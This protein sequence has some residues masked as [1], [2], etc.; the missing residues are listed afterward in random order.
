MTEFKQYIAEEIAIDHADG[1]FGRREAMRRLGL[2]GLSATA[3]TAVLAACSTDSSDSATASATS[4]DTASGNASAATPNAAGTSSSLTA[5]A[6]GMSTAVATAPITFA[7]P[8]G[9]LQ[10]AFAAAADPRGAVLVIHENKGLT[11]HIR[12]IAGRLAG[13]GY[14][15][16]AIDLLSE[17]GGT[18]TFAD[19]ARATAALGNVPQAR[20]V[21]DMKAG[22]AE[23]AQRVP[24]K[25]I[26]VIGFCFGGGQ[27][28]SLLASG[29][30][31]IAAAVPFYGPLPEG[32]NFAGS[33]QAAVLA[34]Y[35]GLD[36]RVNASRPQAE[37]ALK[38][39]GLVNQIE[40]VPDVDHAFFND[41]G[42]RYK[43]E[44]AAKVYGQVLDWFGRYLG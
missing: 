35:A 44:A 25:K 42:T 32:A 23:L 43:P 13:A 29:D 37:A 3:A 4:S 33:K 26:G 9:T 20:F 1:M 5:G 7:G 16:L 19:P 18:G 36:Q 31:D 41:T 34:I 6:P 17:E 22:I 14:S 15:S 40:T 24:G 11:D 8:S 12:T 38:A 39:A 10:G 2:L 27:V 28:W 21:A 30:T